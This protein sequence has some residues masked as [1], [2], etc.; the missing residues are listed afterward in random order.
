[1]QAAVEDAKERGGI[2]AQALGVG[3]GPV[4]GAS[5]YTYSPFGPSPCDPSFGGPYPLGG[6]PYVQGQPSEVQ[7]V[8]NVTITYA[9]Q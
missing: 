9:I 8:A 2:F 4:V 1:M 3:L 6:F 7:L 5:H